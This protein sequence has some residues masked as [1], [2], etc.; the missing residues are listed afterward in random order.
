MRLR[1]FRVVLER[2]FVEVWEEAEVEVE[3]TLDRALALRV[4]SLDVA[5]EG[6]NEEDGDALARRV[7][8]LAWRDPRGGEL[9]ESRG[10][11][12]GRRM[13]ALVDFLAEHYEPRARGELE[14]ALR[15]LREGGASG[16][17]LRGRLEDLVRGSREERR[18]FRAAPREGPRLDS[19]IVHHED[20]SDFEHDWR[21]VELPDGCHVFPTAGPRFLLV[22]EHEVPVGPLA[23]PRAS[24]AAVS[25]YHGEPVIHW[26]GRRMRHYT[27]LEDLPAGFLEAVDREGRVGRG[28]FV[29][30]LGAPELRARFVVDARALDLA[31]AARER[32]PRPAA[33]ARP[34]FLVG[35]RA[36]VALEPGAN[37]PVVREPGEVR[38][39]LV[40]TGRRRFYVPTAR[41]GREGLPRG[42]ASVL[43][44]VVPRLP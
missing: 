23:V 30:S 10:L 9:R 19:P 36:C 44:G 5:A 17:L 15:R 27:A 26:D 31:A 25:T 2:P 34:A 8:P 20:D 28:D 24:W 21:R 4:R 6:E 29:V 14:C 13:S 39:V 38:H 7:G 11:V 1:G 33:L 22:H 18:R 32:R 43:L 42:L 37:L 16:E 3:L 12:V 41:P 40:R 35:S